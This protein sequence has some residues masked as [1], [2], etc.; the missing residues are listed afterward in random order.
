MRKLVFIAIILIGTMSSAHAQD[1]K[2]G[3]ETGIGTYR[4][5][6]LKKFNEALEIPFDAKLVSDFPPFIYY[7]AKVHRLLNESFLGLSVAFQS[8]G[9]NI[10]RK[11]YSGEFYFNTTL[12]SSSL[13]INYEKLITSYKNINF[14]FYAEAG[15]IYS[16]LVMKELLQIDN[17][18]IAD[19]RTE[20]VALN[21]V[22]EPGINFS[23]Q[24][25]KISLGLNIGYAMQIGNGAFHVSGEKK[26]ILTQPDTGDKVMPNW[27]GVRVGLAVGY[28]W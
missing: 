19:N 8:T 15:V 11:D 18:D 25:S 1:W 3:F 27:T 4:M 23:Y 7:Q 9:S 22:F 20:L 21:Y 2:I 5:D 24:F 16:F 26:A 28:H 10:S 14:N 17:T 13:C 12:Y 6:H